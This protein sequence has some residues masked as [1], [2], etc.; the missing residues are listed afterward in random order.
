[1]QIPE[2]MNFYYQKYKNYYFDLYLKRYQYFIFDLIYTGF[3]ALISCS[4]KNKNN[5]KLNRRK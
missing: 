1:M 3:R 2:S 5:R 4:Q